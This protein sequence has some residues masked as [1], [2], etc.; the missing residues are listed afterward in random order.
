MPTIDPT[1][2]VHSAVESKREIPAILDAYG[3]F[4]DSPIG[5]MELQNLGDV[6]AQILDNLSQRFPQTASQRAS[7][8]AQNDVADFLAAFGNDVDRLKEIMKTELRSVSNIMGLSIAERFRRMDNEEKQAIDATLRIIRRSSVELLFKSNFGKPLTSA[9]K[10]FE[11][12]FALVRSQA[13]GIREL[14]YVNLIVEKA[15]FNKLLLKSKVED[16]SIWVPSFFAKEN[17]SDLIERNG[18]VPG[19]SL[20]AALKD[21]ELQNKIE[22]VEA[23]LSRLEDNLGILADGEVIPAELSSFFQKVGNLTLLSPIDLDDVSA[24]FEAKRAKEQEMLRQLERQKEAEAQRIAQERSL[25]EQRQRVKAPSTSLPKIEARPTPDNSAYLGKELD[26]GQFLAA[27]VKRVPERDIPSF[28]KQTGDY[29]LPFD[30][31]ISI[32]GSSGSGKSTTLKRIIDGLGAKSS[33]RLIVVD[34]KGEHRGIAW[35]YKW[36]VFAFAK[37]SQAAVLAVPFFS[38][39]EG[40][41]YQ[42]AADLLQEWFLQSSLNCTEE[43]KERI[44]SIISSHKDK[45]PSLATISDLLTGEPELSQLGQKLKKNLVQKS[46]FSTIFS[47]SSSIGAALDTDSVIFDIS[48]RGLRDATTKEERQMLALLLLHELAARKVTNSTIV[49]EDILDRFR[50]ESLKSRTV[51]TIQ[52]LRANGNTFVITSRGQSREFLAHEPIE[53]FHR[54]SGE[55]VI[56]EAF[57]DFDTDASRETLARV[58]GF[59]PRGFLITSRIKYAG[60]ARPTAAVRVD[61]V[62]F[63]AA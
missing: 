41:D 6:F 25:Q 55:K 1:Q 16:Q 56:S 19:H 27:L 49:V 36:R 22:S 31:D 57:S 10:T 21:L 29:Y 2:L 20:L 35:K 26:F 4:V 48:G 12:H 43:Q 15:V 18:V 46:S 34:P 52:K 32:V 51:Q 42:F 60:E 38:D 45:K 8:T 13:K 5:P 58:I 62:Q 39:T 23:F 14:R 11:R 50:V 47:A 54:L 40:P 28:V 17:A 33:K 9:D 61:P 53:L 30:N 59:L 7:R 24:Y 63:V 37:D 3:E 44:S